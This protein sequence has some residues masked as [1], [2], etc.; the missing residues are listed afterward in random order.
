MPEI[1][2]GR[3][4]SG[5][6]EMLLE[7]IRFAAESGGV[8]V[9]IP[10]QFSFETDK[11]LYDCLGARLFN[12]IET[13][14][15]SA[16]CER[17]C[18]A[19]GTDELAPADENSKLI[20]M[21]KAQTKLRAS[22]K[23]AL[24]FY[25]R[26]LLKPGF[27]SECIE[28]SAQ[29]TR[30]GVTNNTLITAA[31][32]GANG[33][34]RLRDLAVI[35][36]AYRAEL[37]AMGLR[38]ALSE[39]AFAAKLAMDKRFFEGK[40][41]FFN[42][43]ASFSEDE[44]GL[45]ESAVKH[46]AA[47]TFSIVHSQVSD[48]TDPFSQTTRTLNKLTRISEQYS[49]SVTVT[50]SDGMLQ[51][52][53]LRHINL[54][55]FQHKPPAVNSRQLVKVAAAADIYEE[56]DYICAEITRLLR[57]ESLGLKRNDIAVLCGS[58]EEDSRILAASAE[59]YDIPYFI[60]KKTSALGSVPARYLMSI[61]DACTG[62]YHTEKILR[63]VKSPLS[64]FY[65]Y[66]AV[67]LENFCVKWNV[68]G[69]MW[70]SPFK[71][72]GNRAQSDRIDETRRRIIE[73]LERFKTAVKNA[74][75]G[76]IC[77]ALFALL[78]E[79]EMSKQIYSEV[80]RASVNN[81]TDFEV[82]RSFKQVWLGMVEAI[83]SIYRD[84]ND[85]KL[86]LRAFIELLTLML[87]SIKISSP[88]QKADCLRIGDAERSVMSG[89]RVLFIMHANDGF[90]PAEIRRT[91]LLAENDIAALGEQG[92]E[93][94]L[95]PRIQ[96]DNERM[97]VYSS[98]TLPSERLYVSYSET[99]RTGDAIIPS[100]LPQT[101]GTMFEDDI[102]IQVSDLPLYFF[103]TSY[104][105]AFNTYLEHSKDTSQQAADIRRSLELDPVYKARLEYLDKAALPPDDGLTSSTAQ[106]VFFPHEHL[107]LSATRVSDYYKCP[108]SYFCKY[109]LKL[110]EPSRIDINAMYVGNIAHYCLERVMSMKQDGKRV[111]DAQ[112]K[113]KTDD[114]LFALISNYANEYVEREM[115]GSYGKTLSFRTSLE[116]LKR[117]ITHM[118]IN[119]R[120]ELKDS[121]FIPAAFEYK[122]IGEDKKPVLSVTVNKDIFVNLVGIIDRV[123]LYRTDKAAWLRVIDY[124]TGNQ[125]F[126]TSEVY[127]G[128]DLQMLIYL[129]AVTTGSSGLGEGKPLLPAGIM[130]S[131][132][133]NVTPSLTPDVVDALEQKSGALEQTI[134]LKHSEEYKPDG[135]MVG[136]EV[137][138]AMNTDHGGVYTIFKFNSDMKLSKY[139][140]KPVSVEEVKAMEQFALNKVKDMARRLK[141]GDIKADPIRTFDQN[142]EKLPCT[143]CDYKALCRSAD[144]RNPRTAWDKD[145]EAFMQEI[146]DL[147]SKNLTKTDT[148][149]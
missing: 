81:E 134:K 63:I 96:L 71:V 142:N 99:D 95:S 35:F 149:N 98:V 101:L 147:A 132:I 57:D 107:D 93:L 9:I 136:G 62:S 86:T 11:Q 36:E 141:K 125:Y 70:L 19:Y 73:P 30:S 135:V 77:E 33:S 67:D 53:P 139:S 131:H 83:K 64:F 51:T 143:Y 127:H 66:D 4:H 92:A 145:R 130:Y 94:E 65:Y 44:L 58:L 89:V 24:G 48:G 28:L 1:I 69:D 74:T 45:V 40:T 8:I 34:V 124:K 108:F 2:T 7:K 118:A 20:A 100:T 47:V 146:A 91:G 88:P 15:I 126:K 31:E 61:L 42:A 75:A 128:L 56:C 129:L 6:E 23:D 18:R 114:E 80:K 119:F 41:V 3:A 111:F 25:S 113:I 121:L 148:D 60:D 68:E 102:F 46:A 137:I 78:D 116:R 97:N 106:S 50:E 105:T 54:N 37:S 140:A 43:F 123:D 16:L 38:D 59:R 72:T 144:P 32:T 5:R 87:D 10:D 14:G 104:K 22:G 17:I 21:Y 122:L 109:G 26:S 79:L 112:F 27:V 55:F 103:C 49:K 39:T 29:L 84:M 110:Y 52:E 90:F 85:D 117:S 138:D 12:N 120:D 82:G 115:G 133:K 76:E 13:A